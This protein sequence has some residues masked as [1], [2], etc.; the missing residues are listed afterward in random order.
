MSD[1]LVFY[2]KNVPFNVGV[3]FSLQDNVGMVLSNAYPYVA[4]ESNKLRDFLLSNR[5]SIEKGLIIKSEEPVLNIE[6]SNTIDDAQAAQIVKNVFVLK[7]KLTEISSET[8]LLKLYQAAK[9][10]K[11]KQA[12]LEMIENRLAEVSPILMQGAGVE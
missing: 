6:D 3:R 4:I 9:E 12:V 11:R 2:K 1:E 7:K 8:A 10:Q 5:Y